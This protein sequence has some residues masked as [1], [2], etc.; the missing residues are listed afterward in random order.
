MG[1]MGGGGGGGGI[2]RR[3]CAKPQRTSLEAR[4]GRRENG[5]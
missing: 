3:G 5:D 2:V 4:E 1:R